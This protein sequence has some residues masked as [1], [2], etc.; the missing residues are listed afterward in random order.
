MARAESQTVDGR[1][2]ERWA[3]TPTGG[4]TIEVVFPGA[5]R[6]ERDTVLLLVVLAAIGL[7]VGALL[8]IRRRHLAAPGAS[9]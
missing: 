7:I 1:P 3:G 4:S 2:L 8:G 6:N 5:P 9:R